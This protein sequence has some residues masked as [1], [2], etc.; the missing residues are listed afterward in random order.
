MRLKNLWLACLAGCLV[1]G[2]ANA[3]PKKSDKDMEFEPE[4]AASTPPSKT[5]ERAIKLYDKKDFFSASI[6]LKKVLD[7]ESGDDAKNK[8]R[9]EFFMGKTLYQMGFYAGSLAYFDKIVQAGDAHTYH[10]AALKWLAA[11]SRVLPETSGIL[12][13][14][15][16]YD[17]AK[18]EDPQ[19]ASV[20]DEL[21]FLLGRHYYR[22][23]GDGD[24]E[25]AIGLFQKV[26][27]QSEF[28]IK[29][30]FFEGVTYVRK[31]EGRPA[32]DSFERLAKGT[33]C[34]R[35][36]VPKRFAACAMATIVTS[37]TSA[38]SIRC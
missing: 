35:S 11:L 2:V 19:L 34:H 22:R 29:A 20:K 17:P 21:Y 24:F 36:P 16:T 33:G 8:Q 25:K 7:G 5:L 18:L 14:I 27:R 10:G 38:A 23:G 28:Y 6:E 1:V 30:K 32:V 12:E 15:G 13:K 31:Y 4:S 9:A 37:P 3:Q 26:S